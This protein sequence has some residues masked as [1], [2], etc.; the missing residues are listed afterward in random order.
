M[1]RILVIWIVFAPCNA[2]QV[3][4]DASNSF[5]LKS[6]DLLDNIM[7]LN[8]KPGT[9]YTLDKYDFNNQRNLSESVLFDKI[10]KFKDS[11]YIRYSRV[12]LSQKEMDIVRDKNGWKTSE[13]IIKENTWDASLF[14][15]S[16]ANLVQEYIPR[17]VSKPGVKIYVY[18]KPIQINFK[19]H[20]ALIELADY[21]GNDTTLDLYKYF[22]GSWILIDF[23]TDAKFSQE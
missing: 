23:A 22:N 16:K 9:I 10:F 20:F 11:Y 3:N 21:F 1:K 19:E 6:H 8:T 13:T 12:P 4:S 17:Q 18:V 2:Q 14:K 15:R 5:Y 7:G